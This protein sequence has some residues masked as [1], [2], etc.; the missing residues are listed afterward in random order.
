MRI[1]LTP[2]QAAEF[3]NPFWDI[4]YTVTIDGEEVT[5]NINDDDYRDIPEIPR[6]GELAPQYA[7]YDEDGN[8]VGDP[9]GYAMAHPGL[10]WED[11]IIIKFVL[12]ERADAMQTIRD[13]P[14]G[15]RAAARQT[16][17]QELRTLARM[18]TR[19][20]ARRLQRITDRRAARRQMRQDL[21]QDERIAARIAARQTELNQE[22]S[23]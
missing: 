2:E 6:V 23:E 12:D 14:A 3:D 1:N 15:E 10:T 18:D 19:R 11:E 22:S 8:P 21:R 4:E 9:V 20:E 7:S 16:L 17:R 13:L 5:G